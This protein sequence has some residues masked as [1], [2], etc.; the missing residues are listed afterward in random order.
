MTRKDWKNRKRVGL[1]AL[2]AA[3]GILGGCEVTHAAGLLVADGGFGG[4]LEIKEH[5]VRVTVNNGIAV[6]EVT[7]VFQNM[8]NRQVEALYTFPVPGGASV[9]NFSMWIDGKEMVGEV[10]E[11]Q[12]AREIYDSY[13]RQRRDPGLL[14]QKDYK[15]FEMRIFPIAPRAEQKVQITY[16]QELDHDNDWATYV[17][18]LATV[19]Q[20]GVDDRIKEKFALT[21]E[22]RSEVPLVEM[23]SPSHSNEFVFAKHDE[24]F[25][26]ASLETTQGSL[27][28]DAVLACHLSRPRTGFDVVTSRRGGEDGYFCAMLTVGE[29]LSKTMSGMDYVFVL[30][31]SGSMGTDRKLAIS[32]GAVQAFIEALGEED[33][34]EVMAFNTQPHTLFGQ[35]A[36]VGPETM[37]QARG[38]LDSREAKGGTVLQSAMATAYRYVSPNGDRPLNVVILS[39]GLTEQRDRPELLRL[40]ASRPANTRVF[41]VGVGNDVN[42]PLLEQIA[43]EAGGI[44]A[45]ISQG[46]N[47]ARQAQAFRRKLTRPA[48]TDL[49]VAFEGGKVYDVVPEKLPNLY[50]GTPVRF[51]GRYRDTGPVTV[52]LSANLGGQAF[53]RSFEVELPKDDVN[54]PEIDRMWAWHK[55]Q[56][57]QKQADRE[58]S[59]GQV[60]DEIVRLGEGYSIATEHTSFLVL[61]NNAEYKRWKIA[62]ANAL[63]ID[64]DRGAQTALRTELD[65][66]RMAS[67][68][69]LGPIPEEERQ[70]VAADPAQQQPASQMPMTQPSPPGPRRQGRSFDIPFSPGGG[71]IDPISGGIA[72]GLAGL[73]FAARRR[74]G[75]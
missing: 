5:T 32:S 63:R 26:E 38:F 39:D 14:E 27:A 42:R 69:R 3:V 73:A 35:M 40:I 41:C 22:V 20:P 62:R 60:T 66:I 31:M 57:L 13:K 71:A 64:R 44:A 74:K 29:E 24:S 65:K 54:N 61:E 23:E 30:D 72:A 9:A 8:E 36:S 75:R 34:F 68:D 2:I 47:F 43:E 18:P 55:I 45:V 7:Q 19:T 28:R 51:Y 10:V 6:T 21:V 11:K 25:W 52:R 58:G 16:Y 17:Y 56:G 15:T 4:V 49:K 12:R 53:D 70:V 33:R 50:H 46:D 1:A 67:L 59:R 48:A 37:N